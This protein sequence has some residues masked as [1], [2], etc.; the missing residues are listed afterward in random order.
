MDNV[1]GQVRVT[2]DEERV[3]LGGGTVMRLCR[4]DGLVIVRTLYVNT[5]RYDTVD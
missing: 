1:G 3:L 4:Y 5:I 2:R